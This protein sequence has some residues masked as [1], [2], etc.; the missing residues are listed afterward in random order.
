MIIG[1]DFETVRF[2]VKKLED[3]DTA[4]QY[5]SEVGRMDILRYVLNKEHKFRKHQLEEARKRALQAGNHNIVSKLN[6][7]I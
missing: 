1:K 6:Q 3:Y 4:L 7:Y 2:L 5:A